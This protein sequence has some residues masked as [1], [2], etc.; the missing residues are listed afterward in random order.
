MLNI[1]E[2]KEI[3]PHRYPFL[4]VD[5]ILEVEE[6]KR[7]VGIKNVSA[8]EEFFNGHFPEY[9]VMPGVLI[10]EA[11]AQVGAVA[12]L[13][14]EENRG[15]LAFFAGIDSCRFKRQV[16]PGDQLRLEVEMVR[17]RGAIGKGKGV[18][19]VDGEVACEVEIMFALGDKK[20]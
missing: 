19:T 3:I 2:I 13:K 18:A 1:E 10:V 17:F 4:L 7:A 11:L 20:A 5:R 9:A 16:V 15:R 6:G 14:S 8:N 12:M